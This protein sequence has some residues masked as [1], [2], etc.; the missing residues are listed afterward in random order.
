MKTLFD[1]QKFITENFK[2]EEEL[3]QFT[4]YCR[5]QAFMN[6][7]FLIEKIEIPIEAL[8]YKELF[9]SI[10]NLPAIKISEVYGNSSFF[11]FTKPHLYIM[12]K[13]NQD[14]RMRD[15]FFSKGV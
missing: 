6:D 12:N 8:N 14:C 4:E 7:K 9:D 5:L 15:K 10:K 2:N 13:Y 3:Y 1:I 11:Y